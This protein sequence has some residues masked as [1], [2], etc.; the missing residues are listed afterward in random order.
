MKTT[1]YHHQQR[2]TQGNSIGGIKHW[3]KESDPR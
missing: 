3:Q 2:L 1:K